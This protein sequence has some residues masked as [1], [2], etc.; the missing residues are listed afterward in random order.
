RPGSVIREGDGSRSAPRAATVHVHGPHRAR[1]RRPPRAGAASGRRPL[2]AHPCLYHR[3]RTQR[4]APAGVDGDPLPSRGRRMQRLAPGRRRRSL[5]LAAGRH[6]RAAAVRRRIGQGVAHA[7]GSATGRRGAAL[8][9]SRRHLAVGMRGG[10]TGAG[11]VH[12]VAGLRLGWFRPARSAFRHGCGTAAGS[13]GQAVGSDGPAIA[14]HP[15]MSPSRTTPFLLAL[16]FASIA[17]AAMAQV[18][19]DRPVQTARAPAPPP[20]DAVDATGATIP[21]RAAEETDAQPAADPAIVDHETIVVTGE[22][23]GPGLWKVRKG[24]HVLYVMA[25]LAPLARRMQWDSAG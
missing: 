12:R 17:M 14:D 2:P 24:E 8:H 11:G 9:R 7:P 4:R 21:I 10:G 20:G 25:T 5:A 13:R 16:A 18:P 22:V 15:R 3:G 6:T 19:P 23:A 1:T